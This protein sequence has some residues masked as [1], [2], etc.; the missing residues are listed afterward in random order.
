MST[1]KVQ[2]VYA[3][4]ILGWLDLDRL[5]ING[6]MFDDVL[7]FMSWNFKGGTLGDYHMELPS[8]SSM[9]RFPTGNSTDLVR[10]GYASSDYIALRALVARRAR[11]QR[12]RT[13]AFADWAASFGACCAI[14]R[15]EGTTGPALS[16]LHAVY[17][18]MSRLWDSA[19]VKVK[20]ESLR[21][22]EVFVREV[23][24]A[25]AAASHLH[26]P[27]AL[28]LAAAVSASTVAS[29]LPALLEVVDEVVRLV[30]CIGSPEAR[31]T[32]R[33]VGRRVLS[34]EINVTNADFTEFRTV[35]IRVANTAF[36]AGHGWACFIHNATLYVLSRSD[37]VRLH[38]LVVSISSGLYATIAQACVAPG[39]ERKRALAVGTAY[40][41]Q[42]SRVL[43]AALK[44]PPGDEVYA[45][46]GLKRAFSA[47]L[48]EISGP[49]CAAE[50]DELWE[51]ALSTRHA[52]PAILTAW[53]DEIRPWSA[54]TAFNLGKV[55]KVCP[56]PD[57]SPALTLIERHEMVTNRN[58]M[59]AN[60]QDTFR[61]ALRA[62]IL[63]AYIRGPGVRLAL[64]NEAVKPRWWDAYRSSKFDDVPSDEIHTYLHWEGTATMP[65]R[66]PQDPSVWK[67]SGLGWDSWDVAVDPH[68]NAMHGNMLTRMIFDSQC[69]MPGTRHTPVEHAHKID[70]KP[71]G[72]KDPARGI[73]SGNIAER[74]N[75]SWMEA[76]V[77]EVAQFHPA[78]MIGADAEVRENRVRALTDRVHSSNEIAVYYSFDISGWSPRM[79]PEAQEISHQIWAELYDEDLFRSART[80]NERA[81]IYMN[82]G[83]F[84]GWYINTGSNLEGYNGKEMTMILIALMARTVLIWRREIVAAGLAT[85][86]GARGLAAMLLAYIDDG[87]AKLVLPRAQAAAMFELFKTCTVREFGACGYQIEVSKCYPSDRFAVFLNEPYLA[88]HHV[89]H[90]TRAAMTICAEN[91]EPH[92]T[93]LERVTSVATGCRGAVAAGLDGLTATMLLAYHVYR[94]IR[95]WIVRPDPVAAAVWAMFPRAWGGLGCPT[96]LQMSTSGGGSAS[97]ESVHCA[98]KWAQ[99]SPPARKCFLTCARATFSDRSAMGIMLSPLG[100]RLKDGPMIESRVPD[101]VRAALS[102]LRLTSRLSPLAEEFLAFSSPESLADYAGAL[103]HMSP[104][105]TIQDQ[106]LRDLA[107][108]HPHSLFS[109]FAQRIE[110]SATLIKLIGY[111][112][113]LRIIRANRRDAVDSYRIMKARSGG[114]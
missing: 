22:T 7:R 105:S 114:I 54:G 97:V 72:H 90:G 17:V 104:D 94:H 64:R 109:A 2:P 63:R 12:K 71:E 6:A 81:R 29:R 18:L 95:E 102:R 10:H 59:Q 1:Y 27:T 74:L 57:A 31:Q 40:E 39:P 50:T 30:R 79:P 101:A 60:A 65:A 16:G 45:C 80:I 85:P 24:A 5:E 87:L 41:A 32:A 96:A 91:T 44:C 67:D 48:G 106:L 37:V 53:C 34:G 69:P 56:A 3:E 26:V 82:K 84:T 55:Y 47:Y 98:Q 92:T 42:V 52:D 11:D 83:G 68:R 73:Y 88:G 113:V 33:S 75:Q 58:T 49:L 108:A 111:R 15:L 61:D 66:T 35:P 23:C 43:M 62:Q 86:N 103:I 13:R 14:S 99:I 25:S 93:L 19:Q 36:R 70:T 100:G 46:K 51:E 110:K 77:D 28:E 20:G 4:M 107:S 38:Q 78:Y 89:V 112:Q 21:H 76:A 9:T 8:E